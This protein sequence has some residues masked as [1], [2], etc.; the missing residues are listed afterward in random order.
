MEIIKISR[1]PYLARLRRRLSRP[2]KHLNSIVVGLDGIRS[3]LLKTAPLGLSVR[4][5]VGDPI[6][7][8]E[9]ARGFAITSLVVAACDSLDQYLRGLGS[10]PSPVLDLKMRSILVGESQFEN[11]GSNLPSETELQ[12]LSNKLLSLS[13]SDAR[14]AIRIFSE[15]HY[16]KTNR[17]SLRARFDALVDYTTQFSENSKAPPRV[18]PS[19]VAAIT[20]L[21]AWRNL[22]VHESSKDVLTDEKRDQLLNDSEYLRKNHAEVDVTDTLSHFDAHKS[23]TLKDV[24]TLVSILLRAVSACDAVLIY[25][26]NIASFFRESV[27]FYVRASPNRNV[28]VLRLKKS[29]FSERCKVILPLLSG[30]GFV[31]NSF[32]DKEGTFP[33]VLI[34]LRDTILNTADWE[35]LQTISY[36]DHIIADI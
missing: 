1:T 25:N 10:T 12:R 9:E 23:P 18:R 30:S 19:Y 4:W 16:G 8:A 27:W 6:R 5:E 31:P 15:K 17:P 24:S 34:K 36:G 7:T 26:T 33:P 29:S 22:L 14:A 32:P 28:E 20:L 2:V 11:V 35:Y 13:A 21:I 3:G